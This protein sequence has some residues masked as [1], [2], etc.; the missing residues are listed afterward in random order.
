M[1]IYF[2]SRVVGENEIPLTIFPHLVISFRSQIFPQARNVAPLYRDVE[3]AVRPELLTEERI[4]GPAAIEPDFD[5][6]AYR[7]TASCDVMTARPAAGV[8]RLCCDMIVLSCLSVTLRARARAPGRMIASS[9]APQL[10]AGALIPS[11][12]QVAE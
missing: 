2:V 9:G 7:S 1:H 4:N 10:S 8:S 12:D 11:A 5:S 6:A 3:I